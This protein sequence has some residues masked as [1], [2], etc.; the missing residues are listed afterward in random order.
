MTECCVVGRRRILSCFIFCI[1]ICIRPRLTACLHGDGIS[2]KGPHLSTLHGSLTTSEASSTSRHI[3]TVTYFIHHS[4]ST[5]PLTSAFRPNIPR[6]VVRSLCDCT[7]LIGMS[8]L[9]SEPTKSTAIPETSRL[10]LPGFLRAS[11]FPDRAHMTSVFRRL[12]PDRGGHGCRP[13]SSSG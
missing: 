2:H 11:R 6:F 1:S 8:V 10:P 3:H 4:A 13:A 7:I 9:H 12:I 5:D